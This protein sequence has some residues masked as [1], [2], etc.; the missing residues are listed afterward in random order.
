MLCAAIMG[1]QGEPPPGPRR[2]AGG[3]KKKSVDPIAFQFFIN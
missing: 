2:A 1:V 3:I